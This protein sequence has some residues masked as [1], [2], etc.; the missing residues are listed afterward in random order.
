MRLTAAGALEGEGFAVTVAE[1]GEEALAAARKWAFDVVVLDLQLPG[2]SGLDVLRSLNE[3]T[4]PP[5]T[6]LLTGQPGHES[7]VEAMKLGAFDYLSK[8]FD[9]LKLIATLRNAAG[10]RQLRRENHTL[11]EVVRRREDAWKGPLVADSAAMKRILTVVDRVG[12]SDASVLIQ[13]ETGTGKGLIA[14]LLHAAS[15][16]SARPQ[17]HINCSALTEPLLE[18]ELFGHEKGAFTGAAKAK[19]GLFEVA[20]GGT[21]FLDEVAEMS[22]AMQA[23]LL[24]VLDSGELRRVGGTA[25][26]RVDVRILA[27]TN[28]DLEREARDGRFR[29]DLLFR[30]NVV[31]IDLPPLRHRTEDIAGLVEMYLQ[32]HRIAGQPIKTVSAKALDAL[33]GY[34]WP[35]NVRELANVIEGM[36]LMSSHEELCTEELPPAVLGRSRA[37]HAAGGSAPPDEEPVPL[38]EIQRRHIARVLA[39]TRGKKAP[40]AR[41][42]GIDVKTLYN[43]IK[44]YEIEV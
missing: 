40:A 13:G 26:I 31:R 39:Y 25:S 3:L 27:A 2:M 23:K 4:D 38:A 11:K 24:L 10:R 30:L 32:R 18:S 34:R 9:R 36:V 41:L 22:P 17:M 44:A 20:D 19:P 12:P 28:K 42:L 5:E 15:P 43:K 14:K 37:A 21:L 6:V 16:R 1:S 7:A 35:G 33:R 8:P 29:E